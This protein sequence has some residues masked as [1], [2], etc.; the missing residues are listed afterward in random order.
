[1]K[2]PNIKDLERATER[3]EKL[4]KL[5]A[6]SITSLHGANDLFR[7]E[8]K[9]LGWEEELPFEIDETIGRLGVHLASITQWFDNE[10]GEKE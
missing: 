5:L 3:V 9:T 1:M 8:C 2:E 7:Y 4:R 6:S 10:E